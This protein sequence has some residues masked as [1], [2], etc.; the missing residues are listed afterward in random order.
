MIMSGIVTFTTDFGTKDPYAGVM[1]G[2]VLTANLDARIVDI[3]NEVPGHDIV[4]AAFIIARSYEFFPAGTV[5]VVVVDPEVGEKRKNI[6]ILTKR[7]VFVGPDNGTFTMVLQKEKTIE[8]REIVNPPFVANRISNTFHGRDV[9]APCAGHL[10]AGRLFADVGPLFP[11]IR[12]LRYPRAVHADNLLT[13]EVIAADSFGNLI[14]N[15]PEH[16][17]RSFVGKRRH[18][19][20]FATERFDTVLR[21]YSDVPIGTPVAL[22]G[23]SGYLEVSIN[24]G[25]AEDY[26]MAVPGS[27]V[28][29]RRY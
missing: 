6:A 26:F 2:M 23:S 21:H 16:S 29:V 5:H 14:T 11:A 18:E 25:S 8:I 22:F 4:H 15:I 7:F 9:F 1:K 20:Y 10:S 19:I 28:T 17:F 13:G 12:P 3:T 27:T 24:S